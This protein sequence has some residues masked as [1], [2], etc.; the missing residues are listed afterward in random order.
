MYFEQYILKA[1]RAG[2]GAGAG[3]TRGLW[4]RL[5]A[6]LRGRKGGPDAIAVRDVGE[7]DLRWAAQRTEGF[8]G[9]HC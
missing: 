8:S 5:S 9:A 1:G 6:A 3:A 2:G 7:A 4:A